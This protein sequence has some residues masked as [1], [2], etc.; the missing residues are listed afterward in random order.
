MT[1]N[2]KRERNIGEYGC[3]ACGLLK[4]MKIEKIEIK[5]GNFKEEPISISQKLNL[6]FKF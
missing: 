6:P 2:E 1:L 5:E 3:R 4:E